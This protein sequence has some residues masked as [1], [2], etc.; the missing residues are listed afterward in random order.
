MIDLGVY[1]GQSVAR[2][3]INYL[4]NAHNFVLI[5]FVLVCIMMIIQRIACVSIT[6]AWFIIFA[7]NE[8]FLAYSTE[9][10]VF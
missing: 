4:N 2:I 7:L 1:K 5:F 3:T 8:S 6:Q 10:E 9:V